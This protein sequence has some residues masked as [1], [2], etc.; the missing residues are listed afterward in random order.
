MKFYDFK[1][2][3][4]FLPGS[5]LQTFACK[6]SFICIKFPGS[7]LQKS[8]I[9]DEKD[10]N[11]GTITKIPIINRKKKKNET[12]QSYLTSEICDGHV[13]FFSAVYIFQIAAY[14]LDIYSFIL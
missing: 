6:I 1:S 14:F 7:G 3:N 2:N 12:S 4:R 9:K 10:A 11:L 13:I 5:I 8:K